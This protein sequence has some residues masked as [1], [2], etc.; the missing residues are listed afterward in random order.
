MYCVIFK[1]NISRPHK[2]IN[3]PPPVFIY[4]YRQLNFLNDIP[5]VG[6]CYMDNFTF[7]LWLI[8]YG[9]HKYIVK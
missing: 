9:L 3:M 6:M 1:I 7:G 5:I 4:L 8:L 2:S